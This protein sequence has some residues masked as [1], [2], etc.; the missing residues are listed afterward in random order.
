MRRQLT[1]CQASREAVELHCLLGAL[2]GE[3]CQSVDGVLGH[4]RN[5]ELGCFGTRTVKFHLERGGGGLKTAFSSGT[6]IQLPL[7]ILIDDSD[8]L[9]EFLRNDHLIH[10]NAPSHHLSPP[11]PPARNHGIRHLL[12]RPKGQSKLPSVPLLPNNP[13]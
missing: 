10:L 7:S 13:S 1:E 9:H 8:A 12:P 3:K 2:G 4:R 5:M 11:R 6:K